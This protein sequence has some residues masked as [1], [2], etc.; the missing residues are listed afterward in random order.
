M[1][2]APSIGK[3]KRFTEKPRPKLQTGPV[4]NAC[5]GLHTEVIATAC[6]VDLATARRWKSGKSRLPYTAAVVLEANIGGLRNAK[7]WDGWKV[8]GEHIVSPD[9]WT[10]SRNDALAVPLMEAQIKQRDAIIAELR[11]KINYL[12]DVGKLQE[13]PRPSDEIP[14]IIA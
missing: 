3:Y 8:N 2:A 9:G 11:A 1:R 12:L 5:F 7:H 4:R 6:D 13:Q 10:I 14:N